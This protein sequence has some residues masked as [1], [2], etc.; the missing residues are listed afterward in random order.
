M[1]LWL[2]ASS[3][4]FFSPFFLHNTGGDVA[5]LPAD[6]VA[7]RPSRRSSSQYRGVC[8]AR[9]DQRWYAQIWSQG[10][11]QYL[12]CFVDE[13]AAARAYD[14]ALL[15]LHGQGEYTRWEHFYIKYTT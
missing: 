3:H 2:F 9:R 1:R 8:W 15:Q 10:R 12:G 5:D 13:V 4:T 7:R 14:K 6:D 11:N